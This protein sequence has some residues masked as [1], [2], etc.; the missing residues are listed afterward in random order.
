[1]FTCARV[2]THACLYTHVCARINVYICMCVHAHT[3][4]C[5][6][7]NV[8]TSKCMCA[9]AHFM[10]GFMFTCVCEWCT[11]VCVGMGNR[12]LQGITGSPCEGTCAQHVDIQKGPSFQLSK[13]QPVR[14]P[15]NEEAPGSFQLGGDE[16]RLLSGLSVLVDISLFGSCIR[17]LRWL[18][19]CSGSESSNMW[20]KTHVPV[21]HRVRGRARG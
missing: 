17:P 7:M 16:P 14:Q 10:Y 8:Y 20:D 19:S 15:G 1:M 11:Q 12:E 9:G 2:C 3:A 13:I 21:S 18:Q 4:L 5:A 6:R